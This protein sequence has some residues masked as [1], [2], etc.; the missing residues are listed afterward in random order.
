[1]INDLPQ[2]E[3]LPIIPP[4]EHSSEE[5]FY[6]RW[7][8]FCCQD[9]G[10]VNAHLVRLVMPNYDPSRDKWV[11]CQNLG[12]DKFNERWLGA[13][14]DNFD[15]R[16]IP[17]ICQKLDLKSREDWRNTV[18]HQVEIIKLAKKLKMPGAR[19][20]TE[21]DNRSVAQK[22]AEIEAITHE[23]W[24]AMREKYMGVKEDAI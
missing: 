7:H 16:F 15:T 12:C 10:I 3:P 1:M 4:Q 11:A 19:E 24:M 23:Q 14:L 22:K 5:I 21:S 2:F 6:P 9:S 13:T 20:R 8:C 17:A 18:E